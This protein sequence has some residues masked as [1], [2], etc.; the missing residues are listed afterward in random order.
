MATEPT[1]IASGDDPTFDPHAFRCSC[2]RRVGVLREC[3]REALPDRDKR[4]RRALQLLAQGLE[5][6]S[7]PRVTSHGVVYVHRVT[8]RLTL[9]GVLRRIATDSKVAHL[10]RPVN[11][12]ISHRLC[13]LAGFAAFAGLSALASADDGRGLKRGGD[14][15]D[16][17]I[18]GV[19]SGA[20][21][22]VQYAVAHSRSIVGVGALAGPPW[23]C[24]DGRVSQAINSCM[25][26]SPPAQ[27]R[28]DTAR[29]LAAEGKIDPLDSGRP[30][31]LRRAFVFHSAA[32]ATVV[33]S[34]GRANREFLAAFIGQPPTV[35]EGNAGDGSD[36]A[37]HGIIAP[38]GTDACRNGAALTYIRRCGEEDNVRDLFRALYPDVASDPSQRDG[39]IPAAEVW[40][41]DQQ[42]LIDQVKGSGSSVT[43]DAVFW[44]PY[45]TARRR[46]FDLA[47]TGYLYVPP[48]CRGA[49]ASCR[50][51]VALH[52]C[53]QDARIFALRSGYNNWAE[54]YRAIIVYPAIEPGSNLAGESCTSGAPLWADY[55]LV[56]PNPNGCWDWWGYLDGFTQK[57]RYLTKAAPQMKVIELIIREVT[58]PRGP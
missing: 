35:D 15:H 46:N 5:V 52:G 3:M 51:H 18:S 48:S 36:R 38:G 24:A 12:A 17:A 53:K 33:P 20:A 29:E 49:D 4:V 50:V 34:S 57:N 8:G 39:D 45:T 27:P 23:A 13:L 40:Q 22:A 43:W 10:P 56:E 7:G 55:S 16:V 25:C 11:A 37:G 28:I 47:A 41:F 31:A 32:D 30:Q 54:R 44:W 42:R 19:S 9:A 14:P 21:M 2:N 1:S 26:G 6:F 58:A